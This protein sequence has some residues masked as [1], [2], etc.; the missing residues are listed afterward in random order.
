[1]RL[2][3]VK[4][5]GCHREGEVINPPDGQANELVRRGFAVPEPEQVET[6]TYP[7]RGKR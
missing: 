1:M 2:K 3:L 4:P 5:W 7:K 6:A